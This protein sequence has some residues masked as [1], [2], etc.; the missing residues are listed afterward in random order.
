[1]HLPVSPLSRTTKTESCPSPPN[2][3]NIDNNTPNNL[4]VI[5]RSVDSHLVGGSENTGS[6]SNGS[7]VDG[8]CGEGNGSETT[9]SGQNTSESGHD[10]LSLQRYPAHSGSRLVTVNHQRSDEGELCI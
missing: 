10:S 1:M 8:S 3:S 2:S 6:N 5:F 9:G 7:N 4:S